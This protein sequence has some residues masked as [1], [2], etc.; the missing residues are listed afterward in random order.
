MTCVRVFD[1]YY[2]CNWWAPGVAPIKGESVFE[3]L[4]V[5]TFRVRKSEFMRARMVDG[6]LVVEDGSSK[7]ATEE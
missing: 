7:L 3:G 5:S 6:K 4:E 1:D 2:R